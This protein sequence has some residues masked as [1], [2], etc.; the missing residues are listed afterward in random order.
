MRTLIVLLGPTGVGK[1]ELSLRIAQH[2][3][4]PILSADSRQ[5]YRD[6][7]IGTAAPTPEQQAAVRHYFVGTMP[8]DAYFSAAQYEA[9]VMALLPK[10]FNERDNILMCG[11]SMLY[12]DAVCKGIDDIP[13]V[14][15]ATRTM[16]Q[17]RLQTDGLDTLLGELRVLDPLTYRRIDR[18]NTRRIVHA[19]EIC[20]QTGRPYSSFLSHTPKQRPFRIVRIGLM[21]E[22][23]DLFSRINR[24]VDAMIAAGLE[25]EV[26]HVLPQ[27]HL[28]SLN[29]VGYKEMFRHLDGEWTLPQAIEKIQRNTRVYAKK[30]MTWF[31]RDQD[32]HWFPADDEQGVM[33]FIDSIIL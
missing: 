6:I 31:R 14:D 19:L 8:L 26:R 5:I 22:R 33:N 9:E 17:Q 12:I 32:I 16:M 13:T 1:T 10:L 28:N 23:A 20:Y 2:I 4:S 29:T 24:R 15:E 27:R 3:G 25:Q 30:Q 11:G 7:P 21:R 18:R